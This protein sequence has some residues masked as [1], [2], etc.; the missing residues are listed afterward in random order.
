MKKLQRKQIVAVAIMIF[1][2]ACAGV[3][4]VYANESAMR[5][6]DLAAAIAQK[7]N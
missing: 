4:A 7:F 3:G 6:K 1:C 5:G 2:A